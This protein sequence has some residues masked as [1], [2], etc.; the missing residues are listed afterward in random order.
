M[1]KTNT[2]TD[3]PGKTGKWTRRAF[4]GAG[5]V[6]GSALV[7]GVAVRQGNPIDRLSPLLAK[8]E[9]EQLLNAWVKVDADNIVTAVIPHVEMGQGVYTAL[10]QMLADEMDADWNKVRILEAPADMQYVSDSIARDFLAPDLD[11]PAI[12]EPTVTGGILELAQA[13]GLQFTGGSYSVRATGQ[14]AMRTAGAAAREMLVSAA[15]SEWQ[16]PAGEITTADSMILHAGSGKSAPFSKFALAAAEQSLPAKPTLKS[17]DKYTIMGQPKARHDIPEK[18]DGSAVFGIDAQV[19]GMKYAAVR[20]APVVGATIESMDASTA[21]TM[22][23]VLQILNM[24]D[25]VAVVADGYWQAQQALNSI[26]T[27][28][29]KSEGDSLNQDALFA[30]YATHLDDAGDDGGDMETE[31]GDVAKGF[32]GAATK[33]EAE[34]KVPF[35]A[36]ATMEPMNCTAWVRDGKCDVWSGHQAPVNARQAAAD[37]AGLPFKDV[38]YHNAYLGGGFGRRSE[39]DNIT[40]ATRIAKATGYPVK[41]IWS[42]EEDTAQDHYRPSATSRFRGGLDKDGKAVSWDNIHTHLFDPKDA[43]TVPYYNIASH[44]IRKV[45]VPTQLRFGPWRSVDHSQHGF[46]IES[47][48]DEMAHAAG[49]D[50]Y[51]FRRELLAG[52]PRHLKVLDTAAKMSGWGS[53]LP[54]KHG[55]GIAFVPSFGSIVAQVAEVDMSGAKPKVKKVYV[56]ADPGFVINPDGFTAQMESAIAYGLTAA[57]YGEITLKDGKVQQSNF[58]DYPMLRINEMPEVEVALINGDH[59]HLGGGGEP[60][61]PPIAPAV[62]NAI[63]AA[64]GKRIRE[65]PLSKHSFA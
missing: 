46:F 65:L 6:A 22:P 64:T 5:V 51:A 29:S 60:G 34:Y 31:A 33:V 7:V 50:G 17:P 3:E 1:S 57:L 11:V 56:A 32:A 45:D 59:K 58:H 20:A 13:M 36:H 18:V 23:G 30:R 38:T 39:S 15:A 28:Y 21:K 19:P 43:P 10:A 61:L 24:G 44:K 48:V 35:L 47:F 4:I 2:A 14:R 25:F 9:N 16:V 54:E 52:S 55:R 40:M 49:K 27:K 62:T 37:A 26:D 42:R 8:G 41:M 63:F 53:A 12:L